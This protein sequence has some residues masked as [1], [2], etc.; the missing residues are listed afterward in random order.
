[1]TDANQRWDVQQSIDWMTALAKFKPLWIEE[2]TSPDDILGHAAIAKVN[3]KKHFICC[4]FYSLIDQ[5]FYCCFLIR[6]TL[7]DDRS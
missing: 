3:L 5:S 6:S 7:N 1:M 2:P 4:F